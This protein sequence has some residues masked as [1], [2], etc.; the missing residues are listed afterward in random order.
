M[1]LSYSP[2]SSLRPRL[3]KARDNADSLTGQKVRAGG[4]PKHRPHLPF[5]LTLPPSFCPS[6]S[7]HFITV[8]SAVR[9]QRDL[10]LKATQKRLAPLFMRPIDTAKRLRQLEDV[11]AGGG[12]C[13]PGWR[14]GLWDAGSPRV[15]PSPSVRSTGGNGKLNT[16]WGIS[17]P[18]AE[19]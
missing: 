6:F 15:S 5:P 13:Q 4:R 19:G 2:S 14:R 16:L 18:T 10:T 1:V 8:T 7:L 17:W 3:S 12:S 9:P 11:P